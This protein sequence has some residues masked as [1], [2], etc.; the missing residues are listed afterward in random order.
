MNR[1]EL[2]QEAARAIGA[3]VL[4]YGTKLPPDVQT[5]VSY[6]VSCRNAHDRAAENVLAL[7]GSASSTS[8]S[9]R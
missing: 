8:S 2:H 4:K 7:A 5:T 3:L 6:Y 9:T 1:A